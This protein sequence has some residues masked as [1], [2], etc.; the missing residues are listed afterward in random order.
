MSS[1]MLE[2]KESSGDRAVRSVES[3]VAERSSSDKK[4]GISSSRLQ[5]LLLP[6]DVLLVEIVSR[7][8]KNVL[9]AWMRETVQF[10]GASEY[11]IREK[12][13]IFLNCV[14]GANR[15]YSRFWLTIRDGI[16][17]RFGAVALTAH[18]QGNLFAVCAPFKSHIVRHVLSMVG[19]ALTPQCAA[20]FAQHAALAPQH[21]FELTII[22]LLDADV[23]VKHLSLL[24]YARGRLLAHR[25]LNDIAAAAT[26]ALA[27]AG[28][29]LM[30]QQQ[31]Q[32]QRVAASMTS[33]SQAASMRLLDLAI[34]SFNLVLSS[35]PTHLAATRE[36]A[37]CRAARAEMQFLFYQCDCVL[38]GAIRSAEFKSQA[39]QKTAA[40]K[41]S[42][43]SSSNKKDDH[44]FTSHC[45]EVIL[46]LAAA[47]IQFWK[48]RCG[49]YSYVSGQRQQ[50]QS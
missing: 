46:P 22:D 37:L 47:M 26:T 29:D 1:S 38:L 33:L 39:R 44:V 3:T 32:Q 45:R 34:H 35:N 42:S 21:A 41:S 43:R 5:L 17:R 7:T 11:L 40:A 18:E 48:R 25:A 49:L 16:A 30:Q 8:L 2:S 36:L 31:Q 4:V 10:Q 20:Q 27:A 9:R 28:D 15:K 24:S 12:T 14:T 23:R 19:L 13:A 50:S 6:E